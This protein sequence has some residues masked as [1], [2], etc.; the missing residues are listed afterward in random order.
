MNLKQ[1][2]FLI[3]VMCSWLKIS[4]EEHNT[5]RVVMLSGQETAYALSLIG[6][7]EFSADSLFLVS[8]QGIILGRENKDSVQNIAFRTDSTTT[9]ISEV[10]IG[11]SIQ[12]YP[13]PVL[14]TLI[15]KGAKTNEVI[16]IYSLN[17]NLIA[18]AIV[19]DEQHSAI[20]VSGLPVG[21]Y[22]LQVN[23]QVMKLIKQ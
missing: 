10:K 16:R 3:L 4:A 15:I 1:R 8:N 11:N 2:L 21:Q 13:N 23:T 22:I 20:D 9:D 12:I 14:Q 17:G 19:Y 6:R 7:I 18:S 5:L